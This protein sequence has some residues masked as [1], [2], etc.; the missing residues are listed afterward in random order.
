[1]SIFRV[2]L[3]VL[4]GLCWAGK[5][6]NIKDDTTCVTPETRLL[7]SVQR[8]KYSLQNDIALQ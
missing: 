2:L 8:T 7:L 1:M 5:L 3:A 6:P 4:G